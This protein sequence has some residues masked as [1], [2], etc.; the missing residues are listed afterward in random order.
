MK[1]HLEYLQ[2][3][4]SQFIDEDASNQDIIDR[5]ALFIYG[6]Q[7]NPW[8]QE[9]PPRKDGVIKGVD[10]LLTSSETPVFFD[11]DARRIAI[12]YSTNS[13]FRVDAQGHVWLSEHK[14]DLSLSPFPYKRYLGPKYSYYLRS[15]RTNRYTRLVINPHRNCYA[16]CK[17]CARTY[18]NHI[19][20]HSRKQL[21]S[22]DSEFTSVISGSGIT[23]DKHAIRI[24][25]QEVIS[26]KEFVAYLLRDPHITSKTGDFSHLTEVAVLSGDFPKN[27]SAIS[28]VV[29]ICGLL[30]S[31]NFAG[32]IYYAGHQ[33]ENENDM[34][35]L[36]QV[37]SHIDF[38]Y[39]IEHFTR[40]QELMPVKGKRTLD[41][42]DEILKS[43]NRIFGAQN[44]FYYY[45]AGIDPTQVV[46]ENIIRFK[47]IA[48][49]QVF[50]FTPYN[51]EHNELYHHSKLHNRLQ[52]LLDIR[53]FI[54]ELYD[55][56]I[57]GGSNR[58]LFPLGTG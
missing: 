48:I 29:E 28:Y 35:L 51:L 21:D 53:A 11:D 7:P 3:I 5:L 38:V 24:L 39:T 23:V 4:R 10:C 30:K 1:E 57:P 15:N 9:L 34:Q 40:R 27:Q 56:P 50:V 41:E 58:S 37:N 55:K 17:W 54:L 26:P 42:I 33:I 49:P 12:F 18:Q 36:R 16:R 47:D 22:I 19:P 2:Q 45:V 6:I 8:W 52:Q 25:P 44:V 13:P 20:S 43:A 31:A 46:K 32:S 14:S